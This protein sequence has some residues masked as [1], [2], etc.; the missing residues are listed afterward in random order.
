MGVIDINPFFRLRFFVV[1]FYRI[2]WYKVL[3]IKPKVQMAD[4][5]IKNL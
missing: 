2:V 3:T 4:L 1:F 5:I